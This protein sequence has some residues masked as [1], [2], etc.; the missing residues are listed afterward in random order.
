MSQ[1]LKRD[2]PTWEAVKDYAEHYL[3]S[4]RDERVFMATTQ[5]LSAI[6]TED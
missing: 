3:A 6:V 2:V 1:R 4:R 5:E